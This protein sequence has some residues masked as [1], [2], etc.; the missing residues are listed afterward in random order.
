MKL[1]QNFILPFWPDVFNNVD[2]LEIG[3]EDFGIG[4]V[5][6]TAA[7]IVAE[8]VIA[9]EVVYLSSGCDAPLEWALKLVIVSFWFEMSKTYWFYTINSTYAIILQNLWILKTNR[10]KLNAARNEKK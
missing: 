1:K 3:A 4:G 7:C 6:L 2:R 5:L 9:V 10:I 8:W